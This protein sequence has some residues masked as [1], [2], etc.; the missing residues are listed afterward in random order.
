M[1]IAFTAGTGCLMFLDLVAYLIRKNLM[2][3]NSEEDKRI[4]SSLFKF[5][6]FMSFPSR[7][8]SLALDLCEGLQ[9]LCKKYNFHNFELHLRFTNDN[10]TSVKQK[11]WDL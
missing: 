11:R 2:M 7:E 1:H 5:V 6:L 3:L 4:D 9:S 10:K 8:E